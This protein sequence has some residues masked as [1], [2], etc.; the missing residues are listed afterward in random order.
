MV[1][2]AA[3][4]WLYGRSKN[5]SR[6]VAAYLD[7]L[8]RML[9]S[10]R[11]CVFFGQPWAYGDAADVRRLTGEPN[12]KARALAAARGCVFVNA[13]RA[14]EAANASRPFLRPTDKDKCSLASLSKLIRNSTP[15]QTLPGLRTLQQQQQSRDASD[16][17]DVAT[18]AEALR[19]RCCYDAKCSRAVSRAGCRAS[20]ACFY[21]NACEGAH[22]FGWAVATQVDAFLASACPAMMSTA[23]T[24]GPDARRSALSRNWSNLSLSLHTELVISPKKD[25]CHLV[26]GRAV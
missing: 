13:T 8:L 14:C 6:S 20:K 1:V 15:Q 24:G 2:A 7:S 18:A 23:A 26:G 3:G 25:Q 21:P 11:R 10:T 16:G 22:A 12:A 5:P 17:S 9:P 4:T 19:Q